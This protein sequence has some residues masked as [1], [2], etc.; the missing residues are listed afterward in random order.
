MDPQWV[1]DAR[2]VP[3]PPFDGP[4]YTTVTAAYSPGTT[5]FAVAS[6]Q[7]F[8]DGDPVGVMMNNGEF[9]RSTLNGPPGGSTLTFTDP[10]PGYVANG[11]DV[12]DYATHIPA[13]PYANLQT[14]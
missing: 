12:I 10:L 8:T 6:T 11:N 3:P 2:P 13:L 7:G 1:P 14:A 4:I 5:V 9:F